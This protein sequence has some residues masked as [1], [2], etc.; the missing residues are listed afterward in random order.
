MASPTSGY[1]VPATTFPIGAVAHVYTGRGISFGLLD[2]GRRISRGATSIQSFGSSD[3]DVGLWTAES[4]H[5]GTMIEVSV[6]GRVLN[7]GGESSLVASLALWLDAAIRVERI[8]S[9]EGE[10]G[11]VGEEK[12]VRKE[13]HGDQC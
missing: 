8:V 2:M 10:G 12:E 3:G 13:E 4:G 9:C 5:L 7:D 1:R 6:V 11:E